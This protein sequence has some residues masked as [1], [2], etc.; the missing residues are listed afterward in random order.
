MLEK[1]IIELF[2]KKC[3][4]FG[5]FK[6]K[7]GSTSNIYIDLKNI[8]TY[9]FIF[10]TILEELYKKIQLIEYSRILGIPYGGLVLSSALCSKYSIPM[11]LMRKESKKYGL[12]KFI[13]G[14]YIPNDKCLIIED[15]ITTGSSVLKFI[16]TIKNHKLLVSDIIVICDRRIENKYNFN[17]IQIHSIFTLK[18]I[19]T[20]LFNHFLIKET[21]YN[22]MLTDITNISYK[23]YSPDYNNIVINKILENVNKKEN[24][25]CFDTI[26]TNFKDLVNFIE[27]YNNKLVIIKIYSNLI[28]DFNKNKIKELS[29]K[30]NFVV[31]EGHLFN[32]SENIFFN[33]YTKNKLYEW[34]DIIELSDLHSNKIPKII[35]EINNNTNNN[36]SIIYNIVNCHNKLLYILNKNKNIIG[37][38]KSYIDCDILIFDTLDNKNPKS[39]IKILENHN[40]YKNNKFIPIYLL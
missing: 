32:Y 6:L 14:E 34:C 8:I 15:T 21:T 3:I 28:I 18:D 24:N 20:T 19:I 26:Y 13:E 17:Q 7:D 36:V 27:F 11:I 16:N 40:Y 2:N 37:L 23:K 39:N 29:N 5:K 30:Y 33:E 4:K 38:N 9:P 25:F 1:I 12:K 31:I 10:N 35:E 22:S